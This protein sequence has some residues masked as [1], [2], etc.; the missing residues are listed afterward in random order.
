MATKVERNERR[1]L[2]ISMLFFEHLESLIDCQVPEV[3]LV[4][5][6][7]SFVAF[8]VHAPRNTH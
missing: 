1:L 5:S 8:A 6:L 7:G 2:A 3:F 4:L